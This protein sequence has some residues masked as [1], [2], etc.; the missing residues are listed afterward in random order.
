MDR[1]SSSAWV[2]NRKGK[3]ASTTDLLIASAAHKKAKLIHLDKDFT[4]IAATTG[5]E[6][7]LL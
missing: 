4:M 1:I 3:T 7:E 6:E 5:L 2:P